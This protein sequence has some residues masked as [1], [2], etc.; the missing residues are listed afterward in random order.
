[1]KL[2]KIIIIIQKNFLKIAIKEWWSELKRKVNL[3]KHPKNKKNVQDWYKN[4]NRVL[5]EGLNWK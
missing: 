5:I 2:K 4:K 3:L 1:M